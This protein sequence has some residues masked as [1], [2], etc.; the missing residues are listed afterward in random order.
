MKEIPD[1]QVNPNPKPKST[2]FERLRK[3]YQAMPDKKRYLEFFTALL[4]IPVL[5]TVLLSNISNLQNSKN[6]TKATPTP[7]MSTPS[8]STAP[9][10]KPSI[11]PVITTSPTPTPGPECI[12]Q[13][14][15]VSIVYPTEGA[16]VNTNPVCLEIAR[17]GQNYCSVVWSYRI[18]GGTWSD[19]TNSIICMY[20]LTP[21]VKN[22]DLRVNSIVSTDNTI[23]QR[24]FTVA[25]NT[26]TPTPTIASSSGTLGN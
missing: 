13:I 4:T 16:I 22:L 23:L 17:Q 8:P 20:G 10:D 24:T 19:Y 15:P 25:G 7:T 12:K 6:T 2:Q 14:G 9:V 3:W 26:L 21:G 5:L 1:E 18:N 11:T